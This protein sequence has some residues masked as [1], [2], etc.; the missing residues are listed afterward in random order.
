MADVDFNSLPFDQQVEIF[1]ATPLLEAP[2]GVIPDYEHPYARNDVTI[3]VT[4]V[5][6]AFTTVIYT[7][8]MYSRMFVIK[9]F[10]IEDYVGMG[11]FAT[12]VALCGVLGA[13]VHT[14]GFLAH[15]WEVLGA[16]SIEI[17]KL[18]QVQTTLY[19]ISMM[20]TKV[21]ILSEVSRDRRLA[22]SAI[23]SSGIL[24]IA[25]AGARVSVSIRTLTQPDFL[26]LGSQSILFG[27]AE[28]T[29]AFWV[30]CIPAIPKS[31]HGSQ[32]AALPRYLWSKVRSTATLAKKPSQDSGSSWPISDKT[33]LPENANKVIGENS[34]QINNSRNPE[35]KRSKSSVSQQRRT[36]P[37]AANRILRTTDLLASVDSTHENANESGNNQGLEKNQHPWV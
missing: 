28:M 14:G 37:S 18:V 8:R 7:L 2:P 33:P 29:F 11:G 31:V 1:D 19:N 4:V 32:I 30:F 22:I 6:L 24:S 20:F 27:L 13:L 16:R 15:Q 26:W 21:S 9:R 5:G 25:F 3:A 23:F 10:R 17:A 12:Y 35:K 34:R 36:E